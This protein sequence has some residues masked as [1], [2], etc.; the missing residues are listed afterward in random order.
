MNGKEIENMSEMNSMMGKEGC[1]KEK[2][3]KKIDD[4]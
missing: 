3:G 2:I 4:S 1:E